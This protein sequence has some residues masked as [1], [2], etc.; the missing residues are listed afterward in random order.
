MTVKDGQEYR[1][2]TGASLML[3]IV[4]VLMLAVLGMLAFSSAQA[5]RRQTDRHVGSVTAYYAADAQAERV[6]A[7]LDALGE[8]AAA[9]LAVD[10]ISLARDGDVWTYAVRVDDQ[11]ELCVRVRLTEEGVQVESWQVV[12]T[13]DWSPDGSLQLLD[14][15][16]F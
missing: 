4:V 1:V 10:G 5:G 7:Q 2:G 9:Q 15:V 3:M 12:R 6:L 14:A 13:D 16:G 11:R 8:D